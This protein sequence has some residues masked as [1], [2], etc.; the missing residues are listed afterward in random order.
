MRRLYRVP[1]KVTVEVMVDIFTDGDGELDSE[2]ISDEAERILVDE[3]YML[4]NF[5]FNIQYNRAFE[6]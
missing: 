6:I 5:D 4:T 1:V 3:P 2:R